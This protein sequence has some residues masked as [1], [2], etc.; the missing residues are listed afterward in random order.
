MQPSPTQSDGALR[1]MP[2]DQTGDDMG[3]NPLREGILGDYDNRSK[4]D[5]SF[6]SVKAREA[7]Y[8]PLWYS[9]SELKVDPEIPA[10]LVEVIPSED[11]PKK[12][13]DRDLDSIESSAKES[14]LLGGLL[15]AGIGTL[16]EPGAGT[17]L[18]WSVGNA[19]GNAAGA[20]MNHAMGGSG[21]GQQ[22][23]QQGVSDVQ[24]PSFYSA[25]KEAGPSA[26]FAPNMNKVPD[27]EDSQD[28]DTKQQDDDDRNKNEQV[29]NAVNDDGGTDQGNKDFG[30]FSEDSIGR[31]LTMLPLLHHHGESGSGHNDPLV[32]ALD[33]MLESEVPGYKDTHTDP[34]A[35]EQVIML[36]RKPDKGDSM[37]TDDN[38]TVAPS[39]DH[40][41]ESIHTALQQ[42]GLM[43]N[44]AQTSMRPQDAAMGNHCAMCGGT[45]G[46]SNPA[47]PQCGAPNARAQ[48]G[49]GAGMPGVTAADVPRYLEN[50]QRDWYYDDPAA[51]QPNYV[52]FPDIP[53]NM[54]IKEWNQNGRPIYCPN[55]QNPTVDKDSRTC[56]NCG[57][58]KHFAKQKVADGQGPQTDDQKALMAQALQEQGRGEEVPQMIINP[59]QYARE[60]AQLI[61]REAPPEIEGGQPPAPPVAEPPAGGDPTGGMGGSGPMAAPG[62]Q[63][64]MARAINKHA[65]KDHLQQHGDNSDNS[66]D[67]PA[68]DQFAQD[69]QEQEQ[70][71]SHHWVD[72]SGQ[73]LKVGQEYE[74]YS[75]NYDIPDLIRIEAVKPDSIEFTLT[76]EYGLDHRTEITWQEAQME[77]YSFQNANAAH[78]DELGGDDFAP[79]TMDSME[80]R[81]PGDQTDLSAP[82]QMA[83]ASFEAPSHE[84]LNDPSAVGREWLREAGARFTP[85]E[86][87]EFIEEPGVARNADKLDLRGTHY[88]ASREVEVDPDMFLFGW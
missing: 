11:L 20:I 18:G 9:S 78:S 31:L 34:K 36:I 61:G 59:V 52:E 86:Q 13:K 5:E 56:T 4:R 38:E 55:C 65:E 82:H 10:D 51:G 54:S 84:E 14:G 68:A 41:S 15:G 62:P 7:F 64:A 3:G 80:T 42:P 47:C 45:I 50:G 88:E 85:Y 71:P 46:P 81:G 77:G 58:V 33:Q 44:P 35:H 16:I 37:H 48:G 63:M 32:Q 27:A 23:P 60:F 29:D 43:D 39:P 8:A 26:D 72:E 22:A 70:D 21:G 76:G 79:D 69:D 66:V 57:E 49:I 12:R 83:Y 30:G 25:V 24:D 28:G 19:A 67:V 74:M 2:N 75:S 6:A 17:A 1:D 73:P 87:R 40:N 53:P